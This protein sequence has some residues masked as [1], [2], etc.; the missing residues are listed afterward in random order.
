MLASQK[1]PIT[2]VMKA[3][4]RVDLPE[5]DNIR[6][7][8]LAD[9]VVDAWAFALSQTRYRAISEV[10]PWG[11]PGVFVLKHGSQ[12]QHLRGVAHLATAIADE[13]LSSHPEVS[14]NRDIVLAG[15]LVH[16]VG[17]PYEYDNQERWAADPSVYG[18]PAIR[19]PAYG[20]HI[21]YTVGLPEEIAHIAMNHSP[22]E[23]HHITR[24]LECTIVH[25]ADSTWW[26]TAGVSGLVKSETI[27]AMGF[28]FSMRKT[29]L[30]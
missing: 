10:P 23:G 2:N 17:K 12:V 25:F 14:I 16:D 24:S 6:D 1:H 7:K 4:I 22:V 3:N 18:L 28:P 13:F 11:N 20:A 30:D 27:T 15:A 9:L 29:A 8:A 26:R 5:I 21:C 19:H